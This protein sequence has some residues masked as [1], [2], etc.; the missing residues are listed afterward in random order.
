MARS[1]RLSVKCARALL[2]QIHPDSLGHWSVVEV[3]RALDRAPPS[4]LRQAG[5]KAPRDA[6]DHAVNARL[7]KPRRPTKAEKRERRA[8]IRERVFTR[9]NGRCEGPGGQLY[10]EMAGK[11]RCTREPNQLAHAFGRGR[12][13]RPESERNCMALCDT[14]ALKET[15]NRPSASFWWHFRALFFEGLGFTEEAALARNRAEFVETRSR[16]P[17][18]PRTTL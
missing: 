6:Y 18:A 17:A 13:R 5:R 4:G 9:A 12:G 8:A 7:M 16:L 3:Q 2:M 11:I 14:C 15:L 10:P 1:L